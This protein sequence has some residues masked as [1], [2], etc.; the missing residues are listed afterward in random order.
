MVKAEALSAGS[1][2]VAKKPLITV[3]FRVKLTRGNP[4]SETW[5]IAPIAVRKHL[6]ALDIVPLAETG[7]ERHRYRRSRRLSPGRSLVLWPICMLLHL[8]LV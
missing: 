7:L 2:T 1:L 4:R 8:R 5:P 3:E 6:M